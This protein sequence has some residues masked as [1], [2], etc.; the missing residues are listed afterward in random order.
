LKPAGS[1][2]GV[3]TALASGVIAA[4]GA[5]SVAVAVDVASFTCSI[6]PAAVVVGVG[7][8]AVAGVCEGSVAVV[9]WASTSLNLIG[10]SVLAELP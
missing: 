1:L 10:I 5:P 7:L 8:V 4:V 9:G 3:S 2:L 6:G